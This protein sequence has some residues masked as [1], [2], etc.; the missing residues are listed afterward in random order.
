MAGLF[1][2]NVFQRRVFQQDEDTAAFLFG[3]IGHYLLEIERAKQ[4]AR[5]TREIP[6]PI[7][8]RTVP[9]FEPLRAS[10]V[11]PI[12]PAVDMAAVQNERVAAAAA[13]AQA[14]KM[15]RRRDEEALLLLAC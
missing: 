3:G 4:L 12:A 2:P 8:R 9:R 15:R 5:I 10:P 14:A 1:Q 6:P 13:A 7:D 11:A